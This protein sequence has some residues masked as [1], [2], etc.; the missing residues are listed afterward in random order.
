MAYVLYGRGLA[1][2][3]VAETTT[4]SLVEPLVAA[5]LGLAVLGE[6]FSGSMAVGAL[7]VA[8]ALLFVG[9]SRRA[10]SS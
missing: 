2:V 10:T 4:L 1:Q 7:L 9:S 6:E 5:I 8:G 3:P